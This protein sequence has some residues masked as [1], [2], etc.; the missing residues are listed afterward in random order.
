MYAL[1][2]YLGSAIV[3]YSFG[4]LITELLLTTKIFPFFVF[5]AGIESKLTG[6]VSFFICSFLSLFVGG[7]IASIVFEKKIG[8]Y[9]KEFITAISRLPGSV[10][11]ENQWR[12]KVGIILLQSTIRFGVIA[13]L[14]NSSYVLIAR[15]QSTYP[16]LRQ[17]FLEDDSVIDLRFVWKHFVWDNIEIDSIYS[18][19][20]ICLA[21]FFV[22]VAISMRLEKRAIFI[23][24]LSVT[25]GI[26][27]F[28]SWNIYI[29]TRYA[30][31]YA[32]RYAAEIS[33]LV[34]QGRI[35]ARILDPNYGIMVYG[36]LAALGLLATRDIYHFPSDLELG[37]Y[38]ARQIQQSE[39]GPL[40][41]DAIGQTLGSLLQYPLASGHTY[42]IRNPAD[43]YPWPGSPVQPE[44]FGLSI[45]YIDNIADEMKVVEY[46]V[47]RLIRSN[48]ETYSREDYNREIWFFYSYIFSVFCAA[49]VGVFVGK[50]LWPGAYFAELARHVSPT[51]LNDALAYLEIEG[52]K[53]IQEHLDKINKERNLQIN[54]PS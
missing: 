10:L 35:S 41:E 19:F 20:S 4:A 33:N 46:L 38:D 26:C 51:E 21:A 16:M 24:L 13:A 31:I 18:V 22:S 36:P 3:T 40:N 42:T 32:D 23:S 15:A 48:F 39:L 11:S 44:R 2:I 9:N 12:T 34:H 54:A 50:R 17:Y 29:R 43:G 27:L 53:R 6:A 14:L 5:G 1:C 8:F 37:R 47:M 7:F 28:A 25:I 30:A 52:K 45:L 49:L